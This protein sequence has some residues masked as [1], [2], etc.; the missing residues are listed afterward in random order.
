LANHVLNGVKSA[1]FLASEVDKPGRPVIGLLLASAF[2][3][4]GA[5]MAGSV[6]PDP[7]LP[8][9]HTVSMPFEPLPFVV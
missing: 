4:T 6:T 8:T 7:A 2:P 5:A 1:V 3:V 9:W